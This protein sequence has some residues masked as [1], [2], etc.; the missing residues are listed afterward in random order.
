M[1]FVSIVDEI[2]TTPLKIDVPILS[3]VIVA[4]DAMTG[5]PVNV[6]PDESSARDVN[7]E[8]NNAR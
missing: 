7:V 3:V 4:D 6:A 8:L 1:L 5:S 2:E